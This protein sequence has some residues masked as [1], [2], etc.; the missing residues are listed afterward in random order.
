MV[1][2]AAATTSRTAAWNAAES[3]VCVAL[4]TST[5]SLAGCA[6]WASSRICRATAELPVPSCASVRLRCPAAPPMNMASTTNNSQP[7]TA[8][9]RCRALQPPS[10]AA[11]LRL[12]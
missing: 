4:C 8:V 5:I 3:V 6:M 10:A 11:R 12:P 2:C 9:L 1:P 7:N